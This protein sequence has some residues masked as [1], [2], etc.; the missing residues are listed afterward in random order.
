MDREHHTNSLDKS[1][2]TVDHLGDWN[3]QSDQP[4]HHLQSWV[5]KADS[6]KGGY[7]PNILLVCKEKV[8]SDE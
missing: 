2:E 8:D 5:R 4:H 6:Q 7:K 1:N 3:E